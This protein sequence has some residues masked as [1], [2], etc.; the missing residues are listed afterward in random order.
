MMASCI[1]CLGVSLVLPSELGVRTSTKAE[2]R[3]G[4]VLDGR[5]TSHDVPLTWDEA[6]RPMAVLLRLAPSALVALDRSTLTVRLDGQPLRS[7]RLDEARTLLVKLPG[8][9]RGFHTLSLTAD[10]RV[11]GEPCLQ[12]YLEGAWLRIDM[13]VVRRHRRERSVLNIDELPRGLRSFLSVEF[14]GTDTSTGTRLALLRAHLLSQDWS[15]H[16]P[17][18][19]SS[20]HRLRMALDPKLHKLLCAEIKAAGPNLHIAARDGSCLLRTVELLSRPSF[21]ER[22]GP[23]SCR[24]ATSSREATP[25]SLETSP[26]QPTLRTSRLRNMGLA[27]GWE[28]KGIGSHRFVTTWTSS[29]HHILE[30]QPRWVLDF[31]LGG[32]DLL[33]LD[34]SAIIIKV[35]GVTTA[36]WAIRRLRDGD[37]R[38]DAPIPGGDEGAQSLEVLIIAEP[39]EDRRCAALPDGSV[40]FRLGAESGIEVER[41]ENRRATVLG[42]LGSAQT[43]LRLGGEFPRRSTQLRTLALLMQA[44]RDPD[45]IRGPWVWTEAREQADLWIAA[46]QSLESR[47]LLVTDVGLVPAPSTNLP[48]PVLDRPR[49]LALA[50]AMP[51]HI[52]VAL[53]DQPLSKRLSAPLASNL[54]HA[55]VALSERGWTGLGEASLLSSQ[56]I[57]RS[58]H[59]D[60]VPSDEV[61]KT[62]AFNG[63]WLAASLIAL[64]GLVALLMLEARSARLREGSAD[65]IEILEKSES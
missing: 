55:S 6:T 24:V 44:L 37:H 15:P 47:E 53:W 64:A 11:D 50:H 23:T 59:A 40:W 3:D 25:S 8:R 54:D 51:P 28:A 42:I 17:E 14:K 60:N 30:G 48:V 4:I 1:A 5:R 46:P 38:L 36:S 21:R 34:A 45:R 29:T 18:E 52:E 35:D 43:P 31:S 20:V 13:Q 12:E 9:S 2:P 32:R 58:D 56:K 16:N 7:L 33:D 26:A 49:A 41:L 63:G 62:R 22:C 65:D 10:L 27:R 61:T 39:A 57:A 19:S